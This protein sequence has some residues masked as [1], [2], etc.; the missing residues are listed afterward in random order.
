MPS[1]R[2][3]AA[4]LALSAGTMCWA[5]ESLTIGD[6]APAIEIAHWLKG[7]QVTELEPGKI[8]VL[9][10]WAT[11][12]APCRAS[13]P[14]LTELQEKYSDYEVTFIGVSD[15]KL[16]TVVKFLC[17]ADQ[18]DKLWNEKI[19]Y[20]LATD[21][22]RS[23]HDAYMRPAGQDGTPTA[24]I[25]GKDTR[26]EWVGGPMDMDEALDAVVRDRWNRDAFKVK[27]EQE[28]APVRKA[29]RLMDEID[30]AAGEGA[31]DAAIGALDKLL[32]S[33]P[34]H[35]R[36]KAR[37]FRKMLHEAD[38][39]AQTYAYGRTIMREH[40]DDEGTLNRIAWFTADDKGVKERDLGFALEA[41][42]RA[43]ELTEG[44]SAGILDTVARVYYEKGDLK[45]AVDWQRKAL[46]QAAGSAS[47]DMIKETLEKYEKEASSRL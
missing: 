38:D 14:H 19:H 2:L 6:Q 11:W 39:P 33:Q 40:W 28:V 21:P 32:Q 25:I 9:E 42:L 43:N 16:Q 23:V 30:A 41:A 46:E 4:A 47:G 5:G 12:C 27:F 3:T 22:D 45:S 24:F 44:T 8:Y 17:K 31:W 15:E 34:G 1:T 7:D 18:E 37:L 35:E 26:I 20:T 13:I 29:M 36:M 10:F